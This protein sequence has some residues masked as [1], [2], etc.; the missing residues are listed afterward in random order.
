M[1]GAVEKALTA[2]KGNN[3]DKKV[4]AIAILEDELLD[5]TYI[6]PQDLIHLITA[7][8]EALKASQQALSYRALTCLGPLTINVAET[9]Q[10]YLNKITSQLTPIVIDKLGDNKDKTRE[11]ALKVLIDMWSSGNNLTT[12]TKMIRE[13]AFG[14]KSWRVREQILQWIVACTK[15][16]PDFSL[17]VWLQSIIKLLED[18][19]EQVREASKET[20]VS[21]FSS[22]PQQA[23]SELRRELRNKSIRAATVD[24]I[25]SKIDNARELEREF[26]IMTNPF[27]GK[28][29]E[30][31]WGEREKH[32][33]RLRSLLRGGA[34]SK[35][36]DQFM[37]G[38]RVIMDGIISSL[39]SLRTTLTLA[40]AVLVKDLAAYLGPAIDP[41]ADNLLATLIKQA[42]VVKKLVAQASVNA[43]ESLLANAS[44]HM[45]LVNQ[46]WGA[47]QDKSVQLR[48]YIIGF[49]K[50]VVNSHAA[51][52][53]AIQ[54]NGGAQLLQNCLKKGL[55]DANPKVREGS[56]AV[57][58]EFYEVWPE[59][60]EALL[61][62]VE[63]AVKKQMERDKPKNITENRRSH[64][65]S[66]S[67]SRSRGPPSL[68]NKKSGYLLGGSSDSRSIDPP[69]TEKYITRQPSTTYLRAKSPAPSIARASAS[70]SSTYSQPRMP[71][72]PSKSNNIS[73]G[74]SRTPVKV[75]Q[76]KY[77]LLQ[78]L[79]HEDSAMR[80][81]GIINLAQSIARKKAQ[82]T[83]EKPGL[84]DLKKS[85]IPPDE[86]L[87]PILLNLLNDNTPD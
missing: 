74:K 76:A 32:I 21:L 70:S 66:T 9:N 16:M 33:N 54:R 80:I 23:K 73:T 7:L 39:C 53:D 8:R 24:F 62:S 6:E 40:T 61:N 51:R 34:Y 69:E 13:S 4:E 59:L 72:A 11:V 79:K 84:Q 28:E 78:Q 55:T 15:M 81:D 38:V 26:Q 68:R 60:G 49:I 47:M 43:A 45:R 65:P 10:T 19:N 63:P 25:L 48:A 35:F 14:H 56:R 83:P 22:A 18:S 46:L 77:S 52:R 58:W 31:N 12:L 87:I 64:T 2:L 3:L 86:E 71:S 42:G 44:Y 1:S 5:G 67:R 75:P 57:F 27:Q 30:Q 41:F 20:I 82:S 85:P 36:P 50:I 37:V 17:R 29:T